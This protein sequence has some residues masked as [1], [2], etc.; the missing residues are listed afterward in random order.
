[1]RHPSLIQ[2]IRSPHEE[3]GTST[4]V[5]YASEPLLSPFEETS[6]EENPRESERVLLTLRSPSKMKTKPQRYS[7][8]EVAR[9]Q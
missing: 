6:D 5:N 7:P 3:S 9:D 8:N 2:K 4:D 1:M